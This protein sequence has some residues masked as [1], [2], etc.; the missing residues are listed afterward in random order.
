[1]V[2]TVSLAVAASLLVCLIAYL[3]NDDA[4]VENDYTLADI[5]A[6]KNAQSDSHFTLLAYL[7]GGTNHVQASPWGKISE[8]TGALG[9]AE[10]IENAWIEL[11][12]ARLVME[13]LDSFDAIADLAEPR[14]DMPIVS[15]VAYRNIAQTYWAY[16]GLRMQQKRFKEA[17]ITLAQLQSVFRKVVPYSRTLVRKMICINIL[18][19]NTEQIRFLLKQCPNNDII[20]IIKPVCSP[21]SKDDLSLRGSLIF[22][23]IS[24]KKSFEGLTFVDIINSGIW[25]YDKKPVNSK[26]L[27]I[28]PLLMPIV[29]NKHKTIRE[30][31]RFYDDMLESVAKDQEYDDHE[32]EEDSTLWRLKNPMG[33][34]WIY[35]AI[36]SYSRSREFILETKAISDMLAVEVDHRLG[37][38]SSLKDPYKGKLYMIDEKTGS[39]TC[40]GLDGV[41]GTKDDLRLRD[42]QW[43]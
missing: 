6:P 35:I 4:P 5:R 16:A 36:P 9:F 8:E 30:L 20:E 12:D 1:M 18:N 17:A 25:G 14:W 2:Y 26:L 11:K 32:F 29:Y 22:E 10:E 33:Y 43:R 39:A 21:I 19:A 24:M 3:V 34:L 42:S 38:K 27:A 28:A 13:K 15:F 37:L 40:A 31:R 7:K 23:Y 41:H